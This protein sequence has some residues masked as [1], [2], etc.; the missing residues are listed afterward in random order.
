MYV[1]VKQIVAFTGFQTTRAPQTNKSRCLFMKTQ[2]AKVNA[3]ELLGGP[4]VRRETS[5]D[6]L[7]ISSFLSPKASAQTRTAKVVLVLK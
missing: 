5:R 6:A 2:R 3:E 4:V 1:H 7:G